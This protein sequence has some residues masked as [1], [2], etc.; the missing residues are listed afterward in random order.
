[1]IRKIPSLLVVIGVLTSLTACDRKP[2]C[3]DNNCTKFTVVHTNDNHGRFWHNKA[4]EYG[5]A[6]RFT[7]IDGIRK[8]VAANGGHTLVLSGGDINTGVPES[9]LQNAIPDFIGM[10][11]I[12]YD[13]M[14]VGNHEFD[15]PLSVLAEQAELAT[16]PML[17]ANIYDKE[18]NQRYFEPYKVFKVGDIDIAV[19]GLTTND[20][21][22]LTNPLHTESLIFTD[23][24]AEMKQLLPQ[25]KANETVD[26]VFAATHMGHYQDADFG[27]N[28]PGDVT[29]ARALEEGQLDAIIGGHSQNPVC[30]A[31]RNSE[32]DKTFTAGDSCRPDKQ[33]GT[34]IM[35]AH[36]WGRFVGRA[37]FEYIN[38]K[39]Y[40]VDYRLIPINLKRMAFGKKLAWPVG[41]HVERNPEV[42]AALLPYQ[43]KGS[44]ELDVIIGKVDGLL[45]GDR[46]VV[47]AQQTNLGRLI[48][49]VHS[50]KV[51]A[52]FGIMNSG[53]VRAS[54]PAGNIAYRDVLTVQPFS[55]TIGLAEMSGD[56]LIS[57][58]S[59]VATNTRTSGAYAQFYGIDMT[60]K[61]RD[62]DVEIHSINGQPFDISATYQFSIPSFSAAGGDNYPKINILE[63]GYVDAIELYEYVKKEKNIQIEDY[64]PKNEVKF[65]Q[66]KSSLG[67]SIY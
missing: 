43:Q 26:L 42:E 60:V 59:K 62:Q 20:T 6:A 40:L 61:C 21:P 27:S 36:E 63:A 18:S 13:A 11:M 39:L 41:E 46:K 9:D 44:A 57:Y 28:A 65:T 45:Q 53:G 5:M 16:F 47:R 56:K 50:N 3:E 25:I 67:C 58:L 4:G 23:P 54:I 8:E 48:A 31:G 22:K 35:Q 66:S 29:M 38:G 10:N 7:V 34:W 55:N 15:N 24:I 30:M 64:N 33:N 1:M 37:D 2:D 32:Y 12:G 17:A 19:V 51:R 52:D 14:A 49:K